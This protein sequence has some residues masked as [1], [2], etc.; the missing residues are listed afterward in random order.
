MMKKWICVVCL[1]ALCLSLAACGSDD[2]TVEGVA[3]LDSMMT[4]TQHEAM[5]TKINALEEIITTEYV[6]AEEALDAF[7]AGHRTE[8]FA[9]VEADDLRPRVV[10]TVKKADLETA[11]NKLKAIDGV[12]NVQISSSTASMA[13]GWWLQ[14]LLGY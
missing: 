12:E 5:M 11:V 10:F 3:Y 7:V 14:E 6:T 4:D 8:D 2:K 1:L 13:I 9:G